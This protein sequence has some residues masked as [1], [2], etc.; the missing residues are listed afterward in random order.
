MSKRVY[1]FLWTIA[2][3]RAQVLKVHLVGLPQ[4]LHNSRLIFTTIEKFHIRK[5]MIKY[6]EAPTIIKRDQWHPTNRRVQKQNANTSIQSTRIKYWNA[7]KNSNYKS[8]GSSSSMICIECSFSLVVS[9]KG[10]SLPN[11]LM[12]ALANTFK[13]R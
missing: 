6:K 13:A 12:R 11:L 5:I 1:N 7:T 3:L 10:F 9:R 4:A 8:L 2:W